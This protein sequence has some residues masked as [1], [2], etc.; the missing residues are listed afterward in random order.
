MRPLSSP[1]YEH[2]LLGRAE[3]VIGLVFVIFASVLNPVDALFGLF[4][5]APVLTA[6]LYFAVFR[7]VARQAVA[8]PAP[9]PTTDRADP[10][11]Y[12]RRVRRALIVQVVVFVGFTVT[13]SAP[14]LLG[15]IAL[16]VGVA[17]I[18]TAR[19]LEGWENDHEVGLLRESGLRRRTRDGG[20]TGGYY[21]ARGT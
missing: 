14:G 4:I 18:L 20:A 15:G 21:V 16:G 9:A 7:R 12:V 5:V 2:R 6:I 8:H 17:L 11:D 19:W 13:A 3:T 1:V 10:S